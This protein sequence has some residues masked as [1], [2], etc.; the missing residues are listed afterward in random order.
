MSTWNISDLDAIL[1][2]LKSR[3]KLHGS[4]RDHDWRNDPTVLVAKEEIGNLKMQCESIQRVS[5][6]S[7]IPDRKP[8]L[9]SSS[10]RR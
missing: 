5:L 9:T 3:K 8:L 2:S 4:F 1:D 10:C 7:V 6:S